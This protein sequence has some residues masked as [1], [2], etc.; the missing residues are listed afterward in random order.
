M[1]ILRLLPLALLALAGCG[2]PAERDAGNGSNVAAPANSIAAP[3]DSA[4]GK[5][6]KTT[7]ADGAAEGAPLAAYVDHYPFDEVDGVTFLDHPLVRA[8]VTAA[9]PDSRIR[10]RILEQ[11]TAVPIER[12]GGRLLSHACEPHNCPHNWAILIDEAGGAAEICYHGDEDG[13][14]ARWFAAGR[15]VETRSGECP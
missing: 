7:A 10:G 5:E 9:V 11:G 12:R 13:E 2:N 3:R 4:G 6:A 15:Q 14:S 8:A 1:P